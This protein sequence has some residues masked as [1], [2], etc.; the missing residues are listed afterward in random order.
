MASVMSAMLRAVRALL[1]SQVG[2]RWRGSAIAFGYDGEELLED[3]VG[4]SVGDAEPTR[5]EQAAGE[6]ITRARGT[7]RQSVNGD[8]ERV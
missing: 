6:M 8:E 7:E 4:S 2:Q 3:D 1:G 5:M